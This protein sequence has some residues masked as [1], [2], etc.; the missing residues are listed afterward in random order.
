MAM[1]MDNYCEWLYGYHKMA[2]GYHK[3]ANGYVIYGKHL[4]IATWLIRETTV[5]GCMTNGYHYV[6][7]GYS[8]SGNDK[9]AYGC[10]CGHNNSMAMAIEATANG[11]KA[12]TTTIMLMA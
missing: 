5:N 10:D 9:D 8:M 7:D 4:W 11:Y 1:S 2:N 3:M 12:E 6:H